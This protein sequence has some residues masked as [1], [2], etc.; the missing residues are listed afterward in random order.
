MKPLKL[1]LLLILISFASLLSTVGESAE[2][3]SQQKRPDEHEAS[4]NNI[5][6]PTS[7]Q[8]E[9][10]LQFQIEVLEALRTI[11]K[12]NKTAY[13]QGRADEKSW[14]SPAVLVNIGLLIVGAVYT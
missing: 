14:D 9:Q 6:K 11:A 12:Q 13:E 4:A 1:S 2:T 10:S 8:P 5:Q 3:K 7:D